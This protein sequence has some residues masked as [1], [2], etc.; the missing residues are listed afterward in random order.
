MQ[1]LSL[2][3]EKKMPVWEVGGFPS[4]WRMVGISETKESQWADTRDHF[5]TPS[6]PS[7]PILLAHSTLHPF[8][9]CPCALYLSFK[10][11]GALKLRLSKGKEMSLPTK[12]F[13]A[14]GAPLNSLFLSA[15]S[16]P[17][18]DHLESPLQKSPPFLTSFTAGGNGCWGNVWGGERLT[19][20]L[21]GHC[22]RGV[23]AR[24]ANSWVLCFKLARETKATLLP[25]GR[26]Q[27]VHG[28]CI[29]RSTRKPGRSRDLQE[30]GFLEDARGSVGQ[31]VS[32]W[33]VAAGLHHP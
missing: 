8:F 31:E 20:F 18:P 7:P 6:P 16:I 19:S 17:K 14:G 25:A 4:P 22:C 24:K 28:Q 12:A 3:K 13:S 30:I 21:L 23:M 26:N 5:P 9:H 29:L 27:E 33:L 10:P 11:V 1:L 32:S 15:R 2:L